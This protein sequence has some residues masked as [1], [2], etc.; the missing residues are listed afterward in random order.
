M[1]LKRMQQDPG[2]LTTLL[3]SYNTKA[4]LTPCLDALDKALAPIGGG[5]IIVVDN[6][7]RDGSAEFLEA[8]RPDVTLIRSN[9]NV[10]FGRANNLA[11]DRIRSRY[12]L[13]LNTDA[14]V[15]PDALVGPLAYMDA[16][17]DCGV[18]GVRLV[19]RD[20]EPQPGC[21]NFPTP[22]ASFWSRAGITR[23]FGGPRMVD[24]AQWDY[25][26]TRDCDWVPGC[27]YLIRRE[28]LD[29]V[30]LFDP[31]FFLYYEEVDHCRE[32]KNAGWRVVFYPHVDV[33]HLGGESAKSDGQISKSG[34]QLD[35]LQLESAFLYYRKHHGLAGALAFLL[36]EEL[37][38]IIVL[39]KLLLKA[40]GWGRF[41]EV[42]AHMRAMLRT[43]GTTGLGRAGTR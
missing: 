35:S 39:A 9:E 5:Q 16:H 42:L 34:R 36:L 29:R 23:R 31:R 41:G 28:V 2:I 12:L 8:N 26:E 10:G 22:L 4:L 20:G 27:Y 13:L 15:P 18:L 33:I 1:V 24:D 30:G 17:P 32:V 3:V 38:D 21:R 7:S 37:A 14:F 19:G 11:L 43:A 25:R 40:K 6:A